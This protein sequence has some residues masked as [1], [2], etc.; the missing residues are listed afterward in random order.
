MN[1][2]KPNVNYERLYQSLGKTYEIGILGGI[3]YESLQNA[4]DENASVIRYDFNS[5]TRSLTI[6]DNGNGM[7]TVKLVDNYH[8]IAES[9]KD[10]KGKQKRYGIGA[11]VFPMSC[12][13]V[14]TISKAK[15]TPIVISI[16]NIREG[17]QLLKAS[18]E[19]LASPTG[20][21]ITLNEIIEEFLYFKERNKTKAMERVLKTVIDDFFYFTILKLRAKSSFDVVFNGKVVPI[22]KIESTE[23]TPSVG[24]NGSGRW[25]IKKDVTINGIA[26]KIGGQV[27]YLNKSSPSK[28]GIKFTADRVLGILNRKPYRRFGIPTEI[29]LRLG[30]I[31]ICSYLDEIQISTR[32]GFIEKS[33][34]WE[35][36]EKAITDLLEPIIKEIINYRRKRLTKE[37]LKLLSEINK[38]IENVIEDIPE[39]AVEG[40]L[41]STGKK[42]AGKAG[43]GE[44]VVTG[45]KG[46][47]TSG[48]KPTHSPRTI[49]PKHRGAITQTKGTSRKKKGAPPIEFISDKKKGAVFIDE[50]GVICINIVHKMFVQHAK[51]ATLH[52]WYIVDLVGTELSSKIPI[53]QNIQDDIPSIGKYIVQ[54]KKEFTEKA[55]EYWF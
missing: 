6:T 38:C 30:G 35:E 26:H 2:K 21:I 34:V 8:G 31:F 9:D 37:E 1:W 52:K 14:K 41:S 11:S 5:K 29:S 28:S 27:Y 32:S 55:T 50:K 3:F 16:W 4:M 15:T 18:S 47:K 24:D 53:P 54:K 42:G 39:F 22:I 17:Y 44:T 20:T 19:Q 36:H 33:K 51:S 48:K 13:Q 46:T 40:A 25:A 45:D 43:K 12:K 10:H 49:N 7:D 23:L